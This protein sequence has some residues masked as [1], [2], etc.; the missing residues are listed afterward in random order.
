LCTLPLEW[1]RRAADMALQRGERSCGEEADCVSAVEDYNPA[2]VRDSQNHQIEGGTG[3]G[4]FAEY[5]HVA[6][7]RDQA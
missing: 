1:K 3:H 7:H 2:G 6:A 4:A 5:C